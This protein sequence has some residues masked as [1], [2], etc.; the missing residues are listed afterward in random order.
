MAAEEWGEALNS[1]FI[2]NSKSSFVSAN[3]QCSQSVLDLMVR[4]NIPTTAAAIRNLNE[5]QVLRLAMLASVAGISTWKRDAATD[6]FFLLT[7][8]G[9]L[10]HP[11]TPNAVE[12]DVMLS[13]V[14]ILLVV[15]AMAHLSP[16]AA[17]VVIKQ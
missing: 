14:C 15:I 6:S 16:A 7:D 10:V 12:T 1:V 11:Y 5:S 13:V 4:Q 17:A 2:L 3:S 9:R 8:Q